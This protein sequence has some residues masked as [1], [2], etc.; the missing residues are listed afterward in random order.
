MSRK[1]RTD[2]NN[3]FDNGLD[4]MSDLV[5]AFTKK[6]KRVH[7]I[8][9]AE[10]DD[11]VQVNEQS[12]GLRLVS[13]HENEAATSNNVSVDKENGNKQ[14]KRSITNVRT[15]SPVQIVE[16]PPEQILES[17]S[18]FKH[19][20]QLSN[21]QNISLRRSL[22]QQQPKN[23]N[24]DIICSTPSSRNQGISNDFF[25][26]SSSTIENISPIRRGLSNTVITLDDLKGIELIPAENIQ[27]GV[28]KSLQNLEKDLREQFQIDQET[29]KKTYSKSLAGNSPRRSI[30]ESNKDASPSRQSFRSE[31]ISRS[32]PT[33][34]CSVMLEPM[35]ISKDTISMYRKTQLSRLSTSDRT[36][37]NTFN[38]IETPIARNNK[39]SAV[40][41][42]VLAQKLALCASDSE[43][44]DDESDPGKKT[45]TSTRQSQS[46]NRKTVEAEAHL[47]NDESDQQLESQNRRKTNQNIES[48]PKKA[49]SRRPSRQSAP[50]RQ[51]PVEVQNNITNDESEKDEEQFELVID[52][53]PEDSPSQRPKDVTTE[54]QKSRINNREHQKSVVASPKKLH[55]RRPSKDVTIETQ[56]S[57]INDREAQKSVAASPKKSHSRRSPKDVVAESHKSKKNE[58]EVHN[59]SSDESD[60][61]R[62]TKTDR[63]IRKNSQQIDASP[64]KVPPRRPSKN[65]TIETQ[66][67]RINDREAEKS[68]A[69]TPKKLPSRRPS[70]DVVAES[71]KSKKNDR[72]IQNNSSDESDQDEPQTK[73]DKNHK[74]KVPEPKK[75]VSEQKKS[76]HTT[77]TSE[78]MVWSESEEENE[79]KEQS[80]AQNSKQ[81]S[82]SENKTARKSTKSSVQM[83]MSE[84][85]PEDESTQQDTRKSTMNSEQMSMSEEESV[86]KI[87]PKEH[88]KSKGNKKRPQSPIPEVPEHESSDEELETVEQKDSSESEEETPVKVQKPTKTQKADNI[89]K[90]DKKPQKGIK[91]NQKEASENEDSEAQNSDVPSKAQ[92]PPKSKKSSANVKQKKPDPP[93]NN[94][95]TAKTKILE[96]EDSESDEETERNQAKEKEIE[97]VEQ[98]KKPALFKKSL[99]ETISCNLSN[100]SAGSLV[101]TEIAES[102]RTL[103]K[104][105]NNTASIVP[106]STKVSRPRTK[107]SKNV[108]PN[109]EKIAQ[110]LRLEK[111]IKPKKSKNDIG[112]SRKRTLFSQNSDSDERESPVKAHPENP[113]TDPIDH[114]LSE[115][116][117]AVRRSIDTMSNASSQPFNA[118]ISTPHKNYE[119]SED[120]RPKKNAKTPNKKKVVE[121]S[122]QEIEVVEEAPKGRGRSRR[123]KEP[124]ESR[125]KVDKNQEQESKGRKRQEKVV[126]DSDQE[127]EVVEEAPKGRG[128]SKRNK[129]PI[130]SRSKVNKDQELKSKGQKRQEQ[131]EIKNAK[132]KKQASKATE[133]S[134]NESE[135]ESP[136]K[137]SKTVKKPYMSKELKAL[138]KGQ[139]GKRHNNAEDESEPPTKTRRQVASNTSDE[140]NSEASKNT[141]EGFQSNEEDEYDDVWYDPM[142]RGC[143]RQGLRVRKFMRSKD[144]KYAIQFG[145]FTKNDSKATQL[146]K[147]YNIKESEVH[148]PSLAPFIQPANKLELI[149]ALIMERKLKKKD[150]PPKPVTKNKTTTEKVNDGASTSRQAME[151]ESLLS[152]RTA[153]TNETQSG[154]INKVLDSFDRLKGENTNPVNV[155]ETATY[156]ISQIN[157]LVWHPIGAGVFYSSFKENSFDGFLKIVKGGYKKGARTK[158]A[159]VKMTLLCGV[160]DIKINGT[161]LRIENLGFITITRGQSYRIM[162]A[163][164]ET[165]IIL[166][167]RLDDEDT[168][169][170]QNSSS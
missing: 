45:R 166:M 170:N 58:R 123:N 103:Q 10:D 18:P 76:V 52:T 16:A 77:E 5:H 154:V 93:K 22:F 124:I 46:K 35:E 162:N 64:K 13:V 74:K 78:N 34:N 150:D 36:N 65:V 48:T 59:N 109:K 164:D 44:T 15:L 40:N 130:D 37:I 54:I 137:V 139:V 156:A 155:V 136:Q 83:S 116:L 21:R 135:E 108:N 114:E 119:D 97:Q 117:S 131:I 67:S 31:P 56:K 105:G 133:S 32:Q 151:T 160:V 122:D 72:H 144:G 80:S 47:T 87:D 39:Y 38:M 91:K 57:R 50:T 107:N 26:A 23:K 112:K 89:K 142:E 111:S 84:S 90:N 82:V 19:P 129:E 140:N 104:P 81:M 100:V 159:V 17:R 138:K 165:A 163:S 118:E 70:K 169:T 24:N 148:Q 6:N 128:R 51:D 168:N 145:V 43:I 33:Q 99:R 120:E 20:S 143:Q 92:T 61:D 132:A 95:K 2:Y 42:S 49:P 121:D 153:R 127:M 167:T 110:Y 68:V 158:L 94:K 1:T 3:I 115:E 11:D 75:M 29:P 161:K 147:K 102:F 141:D 55:S 152:F 60:D 30:S 12:Y 9:D 73:K 98:F 41:D 63:N 134:D 96:K 79:S 146:Q 71:R 126:E 149:Q 4:N 86:E 7:R 88:R 62:H 53:S 8:F 69:L 85:E 28:V 113:E 157:R 101:P 25:G 66:K 27:N 125:S 106:E 14:V